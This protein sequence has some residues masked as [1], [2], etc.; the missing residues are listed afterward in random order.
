MTNTENAESLCTQS[1]K[2][3]EAE[4]NWNRPLLCVTWWTSQIWTAALVAPPS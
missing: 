4:E 3:S 1:S 2:Y